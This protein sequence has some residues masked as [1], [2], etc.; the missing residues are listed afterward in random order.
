MSCIGG[1]ADLDYMC[2]LYL[3]L[4]LDISNM[5]LWHQCLSR[6]AIVN[7]IV[8]WLFCV[9][10][11]AGIHY[12][13][14]NYFWLADE[15][16]SPSFFVFVLTIPCRVHPWLHCCWSFSVI[17]CLKSTRILLLLAMTSTPWHLMSSR[18]S[19]FQQ[20]IHECRTS[21]CDLDSCRNTV[22]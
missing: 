5:P 11:W 13:W 10:D 8:Y 15:L 22:W 20:G 7:Q 14:N 1:H 12:H 17:H 6:V 3:I 9:W 21:Q 2:I 18:D 4:E 16:Q 19:L